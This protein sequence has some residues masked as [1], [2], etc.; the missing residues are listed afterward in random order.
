MPWRTST[1]ENER[2]RFVLEAEV[3]HLSHS[4]LCRRHGISRPT[5]YKWIRRFEEED[6]EGL[7]DRSHRPRSCPHATTRTPPVSRR[8]RRCT[9]RCPCCA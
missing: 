4:E 6:L 1:V 7:R 9:W 3:S 2:A 8:S 5:G